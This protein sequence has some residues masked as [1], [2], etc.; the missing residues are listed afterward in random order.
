MGAIELDRMAWPEVRAGLDTGR[1]WEAVE[2]IA[3]RAVAPPG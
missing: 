2:T 3:L 1:D